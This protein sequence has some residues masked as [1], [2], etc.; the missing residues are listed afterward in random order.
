[1]KI[2]VFTAN[3]IRHKFLANNLA[4]AADEALIVCE[5][6]PNDAAKEASTDT[7]TPQGEHFYLRYQA[8]KQYFAG[9]DLFRFPVLPLMKKEA[10]LLYTYDVIKAFEP[11][12]MFC[13][14]ASII[15]EP[16]L[17]LL[18]PGHFVNL[19]LGISPYYRGSGTNFFPFVNDELQYVGSTLLHIDAGIDTG[20]IICHVRPKFEKGDTVHSVGCKV[21]QSSVK[22]MIKLME[23]VGR[24]ESLN[25][26]KQWKVE[27]ERYYR[28]KDFNDDI[29]ATYKMNLENGMIEKHLGGKKPEIKLIS[30]NQNQ[31]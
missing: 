11:D 12:L 13:F 23:Q 9:N 16:L 25:R 21:I 7:S 18:D 28:N 19:H 15:R 20:D 30:L 27:N 3:A 26:V 24:G 29:L 4:K 17:S 31:S 5:C 2:V 14:G 22:T 8:E 10:S 6:K 1:M